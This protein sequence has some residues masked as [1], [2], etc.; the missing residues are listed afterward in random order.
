M[1][2]HKLRNLPYF[3][4]EKVFENISG[5]MLYASQNLE[6]KLPKSIYK[7]KAL[8]FVIGYFLSVDKPNP[9]TVLTSS[10]KLDKNF[11]IYQGGDATSSSQ[12]RLYLSLK[13]ETTLYL[14]TYDT[15]VKIYQILGL[16]F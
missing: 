7:Y 11:D 13:D 2:I 3:Y 16:T 12:R 14:Q 4:E 15:E 9:T 6:I 10:F 8:Y 5:K 1:S